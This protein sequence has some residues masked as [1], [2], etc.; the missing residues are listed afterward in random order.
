[1]NDQSTRPVLEL[2][3]SHWLSLLGA[4]LVT[5]A[6]FSWLFVLPMQ[7][8]GNAGN[9]YIG[10]VVFIAIP[11]IFCLGLALI[12][13]GAY[14]A[15][16]RVKE[17]LANI[18]DR[19]TSLRR[20]G[21]F[22]GGAT[23]ANLVI[24]TQGTYR[25]VEHMETVQFC[26]QSCHV[27][28]PEFV[29]HD[30]APHSHVSCVECH[31]APGA[32]G[33]VRSKMAGVRQLKDIMFNSYPRPIPSA[34]ESSRLVPASET[35]EQC[36]WPEKQIAI[37]LRIIP[38]FKDNEANT[39][40]QTVLMMSIGG[41]KSGGIHGAHFGPGVEIRYAA[42]DPKR[43]TIP[44][45]QYRNRN[46]NDFRTYLAQDAKPESVRNLPQFDMQ[47]VDCHNRP[48]HAFEL[49][50]RAVNRALA[51]GAL[52]STLPYIKK[53]SVELLNAEYAG[54]E[55][56]SQKIRNGIAGFYQGTYPDVYARRSLDITRAADA[57]VSI[58]NR[59]VF[60]DL[61]VTW[62]TYPNNLGHTD[63]AGCFRCHDEA[64]A[65]SGKK[66]ITQD[67]SV[68]HNALAVDEAAPEVLKTLGLAKP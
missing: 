27:M 63:S 32:T 23:L 60:P 46:T 61:K 56:A 65:S 4:A 49:P 50:E 26:G 44:W 38:N 22:L 17:G 35:C 48:T 19:K 30:N 64:H 45:V 53:K 67:C 5:T 21:I 18:L 25:A 59:N 7:V 41:G 39:A 57:L 28:Q 31:V 42:A 9:P 11:V 24:G 13:I 33:W 12:P 40:S 55:E 15:R 34:M 8:R 51:S 66:T 62:G 47:C 37:R 2:L 43:Q 16:R 1:V 3:A 36:H 54:T 6:G 68:C 29:S 10:L 58:Y 52:S 14:L 20:L